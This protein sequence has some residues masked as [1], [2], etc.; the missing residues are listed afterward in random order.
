MKETFAQRLRRLRTARALSIPAV[1]KLVGVTD[2]A[3]RQLES[4]ESKSA[5]F[6]V[7]IRLS[8]ILEV[9]PTALAFGEEAGLAMRLASVERRLS[10][11]ETE[12]D[13]KRGRAAPVSAARKSRS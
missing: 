13:E 11:L 12:R 7:G 8:Q 9:D 5:S 6:A 2:S 3:I 1:A 4:G 10:A